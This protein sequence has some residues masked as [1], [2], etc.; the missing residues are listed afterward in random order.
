VYDHTVVF[1]ENGAV[2]GGGAADDHLLPPHLY[3]PQDLSHPDSW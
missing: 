2:G 1:R 3:Q